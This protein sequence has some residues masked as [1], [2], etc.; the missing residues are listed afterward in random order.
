MNNKALLVIDIQNDF[1]SDIA[2]MPVD[3]NQCE[4]IIFKINNLIDSA[5]EKKMTVIY[6][7]N[8]YSKFDLWNI[9]RNFASIKI[10]RDL[11]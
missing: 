11:N 8:E 1:T 5:S 7:G 2:R 6:I 9:F 3:V 10:H 4:S